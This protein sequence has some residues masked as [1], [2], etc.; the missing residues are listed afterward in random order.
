MDLYLCIHGLGGA[1]YGRRRLLIL[2]V[3]F[4]IRFNLCF[5][6]QRRNLLVNLSSFQPPAHG[7]N[8]VAL[9]P[10]NPNHA[11]PKQIHHG[12]PLNAEHQCATSH[13]LQVAAMDM[14]PKLV[15]QLVES[16]NALADEVQNLTDRK[17]ILEHKLRY[18][19]E[20]VCLLL[21]LIFFLSSLRMAHPS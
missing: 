12:F 18:A 8:I 4:K 10:Q 7:D 5:K 11:I 15:R 1:H 13:S 14:D 17:T 21:L 3:A 19:H 16:F 6:F 9:S 2:I 20:Q